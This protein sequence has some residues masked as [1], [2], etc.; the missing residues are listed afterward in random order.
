M[1]EK[2]R[3]YSPSESFMPAHATGKVAEFFMRDLSRPATD[4]A[5]VLRDILKKRALRKMQSTQ[6][7]SSF[8]K[9]GE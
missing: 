3:K 9:Q 4:E 1:S 6:K 8:L 7:S 2:L 5:A